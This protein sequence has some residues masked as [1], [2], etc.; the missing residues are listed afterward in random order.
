MRGD[1]SARK[2][3]SGFGARDLADDRGLLVRIEVAV[4]GPGETQTRIPRA[5]LGGSCIERLLLGAEQIDPVA[6]ALG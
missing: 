5:E 2:T 6:L 3:M 1:G 4:P